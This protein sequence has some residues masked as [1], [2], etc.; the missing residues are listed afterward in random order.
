MYGVLIFLIIFGGTLLTLFSLMLLD[1]LITRKPEAPAPVPIFPV[2]SADPLHDSTGLEAGYYTN[3]NTTSSEGWLPTGD[4]AYPF[5]ARCH[6]PSNSEGWLPTGDFPARCY[7]SD[8]EGW[9]PTGDLAYPF[10][11]R[12]YP[13]DSEGWLPIGVDLDLANA[14][15][16]MCAAYGCGGGSVSHDHPITGDPPNPPE[17]P[18]HPEAGGGKNGRD[19]VDDGNEPPDPATAENEGERKFSASVL[20][21]PPSP[22]VRTGNNTDEPTSERQKKSST[23]SPMDGSDGHGNSDESH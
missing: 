16:C 9:L 4:L 11:A 10:P 1:Y 7:P 12:C 18:R 2:I 13:S 22:V 15:T 17:L 14:N 20:P 6:Y 19:A 21:P 8:S 5:P 3:T 23:L